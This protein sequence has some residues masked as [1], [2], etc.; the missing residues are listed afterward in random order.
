MYVNGGITSNKRIASMKWH[1]K[2]HWVRVNG[3]DSIKQKFECTYTI[4]MNIK[5]PNNILNNN[6]KKIMAGSCTIVKYGE[7]KVCDNLP[8]KW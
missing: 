6:K 7:T 2:G 4:L 3:G 1:I 8:T 5:Y